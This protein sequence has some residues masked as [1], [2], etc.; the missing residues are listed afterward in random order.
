[1]IHKMKY[2]FKCDTPYVL[3]G[4]RFVKGDITEDAKLALSLHYLFEE[5]VEKVEEIP[6][7]K[8]S[9][10]DLQKL[11]EQLKIE[12]VKSWS[13]AKLINKIKNAKEC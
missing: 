7:E 6:L 8:M 4:R 3:N 5:V 2:R 10:T 1:M 11:A 13:R 12:I 9:I